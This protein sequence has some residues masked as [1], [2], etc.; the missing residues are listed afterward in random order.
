M[1]TAILGAAQSL[2]GARIDGR[3]ATVLGTALTDRL[4]RLPVSFFRDFA[5]GDLNQRIEN[6][7][8]MRR[9]GMSVLLSAGM[10]AV[11]SAAYLGVLLAYDTSL[12]VIGLVLV[13]GYIL[14]VAISRVRQMPAL[15]KAARLDGDI[16]SLTYET[17]DGIGKLRAAAAE[18]R[19]LDRWAE[20][21]GRE[22]EAAHEAGRVSVGFGA[23]ADAYQI[24]T[25]MTLF[26]GAGAL[27][28]MEAPAGIFIGFLAAFGSFQAAFVGLSE[29]LLQVYAA[30]P[31]VER[32]RPILDAVPEAAA[33]RA[34]PG[35]LKGEIEG[36][37][38]V[39]AYDSGSALVLDGLDFH[40]RPGEHMAI[41]GG[42]GSG[43]STLLRLL[44]GF[45][46]PQRGAILY[47]GQDLAHL[48]L[49]RV[50]GQIGVV[51]QASKLFAGSI[52]DNIRGAS[53]ASLE[54][55]LLAAE[56]AGLSRD[57]GYFAMGV[58]TPITEG[59]GTLSG[60][61][62]Q[63]I[64][65]A[66]ALASDPRILF[67]DEATSALDNA[68][69]AQ[70]SATLEALDVT[71]VT[72]AHRLSTVRHA[73]RICVMSEGRFAEQGTYDELMARD[74]VF[75]RLAKRQLTGD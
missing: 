68:T 30:Q 46:T 23:F 3:G 15:R 21:Y 70:V 34:D 69:Q 2:A 7:E 19:A 42:S 29:A 25:L 59:A 41:V 49:T 73:D 22:R 28:A 43:K 20:L 55:C 74:G 35:N 71:R 53:G 5:A 38:L 45:E 8:A 16:A 1:V 47:D 56:R 24:V 27:V 48:D 58:H 57:L 11:L 75:A 72:I 44:L 51:L 26:A 12:A 6:V 31:L 37:G 52:V 67:F 40:V 61:Q 17:L 62:R 66:R 64:L 54:A 60:G 50:R 63:R 33:G 65:I 13:A 39:F 18:E 36:S 10:T 14:G 9:L 4:L 32:A